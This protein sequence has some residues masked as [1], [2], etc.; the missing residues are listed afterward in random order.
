M[1]IGTPK[2]THINDL[3][4]NTQPWILAPSVP[5]DTKNGKLTRRRK[6]RQGAITKTGNP[7]Q[8]HSLSTV[9]NP[10]TSIN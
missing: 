5:S 1:S 9:Q 6:I 7:S 3:D 8:T 2:V 10:R 4:I